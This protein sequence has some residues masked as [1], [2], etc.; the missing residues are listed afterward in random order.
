MQSTCS[1]EITLLAVSH[2]QIRLDFG[3][4]GRKDTV[5]ST[6]VTLVH[7]VDLQGCDI[8]C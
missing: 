5:N 6:D 7:C 2:V 3:D 1:L 8:I 4:H